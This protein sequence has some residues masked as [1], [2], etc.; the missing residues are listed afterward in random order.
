MKHAYIVTSMIQPRTDIPLTYSPI[1]SY[2]NADDRLKHTIMTIASLD[3]LTDKRSSIIYLLELSEH[4]NAYQTYFGYQS[5]LKFINVKEEFPE[6]Y[7][8]ITSHAN[9]S[10]CETLL[11]SYFL[12]KYEQELSDC[13]FITKVSGRYFLDGSFDTSIFSPENSN[14]LFFKSPLAYE[15]KDE[16]GYDF[17]DLRSKTGDNLLRQYSSVVFTW[18]KPYYT[19]ILTMYDTMADLLSRPTMQHYDIE[20]LLYFLTREYSDDI[21]ETDWIVY[22][23]IGPTG[24]F[25]RY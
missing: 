1:R 19:K 20:T 13:E 24:Q 4:T 14:K 10:R 5:N 16:W 3:S 17:V 8:E 6:I 2:F 25:T 23:W 11:M 15:W 9:K 22:G 18:T 21:I 7:R 12:K